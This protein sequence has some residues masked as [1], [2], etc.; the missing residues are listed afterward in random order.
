[1]AARRSKLTHLDAANRPTMVDVGA[2]APTRREASADVATFPADRI[3]LRR[4]L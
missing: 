2:K 1:M 3:P 4:Q